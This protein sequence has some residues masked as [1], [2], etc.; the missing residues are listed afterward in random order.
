MR[1]SRDL[2]HQNSGTLEIVTP[3]SI[4]KSSEH[5]DR[6]EL[7][8]KTDSKNGK[9]SD[10]IL[11]DTQIQKKDLDNLDKLFLQQPKKSDSTDPYG[12]S[13]KQEEAVTISPDLRKE[14]K[15]GLKH[16]DSSTFELKDVKDAYYEKK[17]LMMGMNQEFV[18]TDNTLD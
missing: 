10:M 9:S 2:T 15:K 4:Q 18:E 3:L 17:N 11:S 5:E 16:V 13:I 8:N 14:F 12:S 6:S 7:T 1:A